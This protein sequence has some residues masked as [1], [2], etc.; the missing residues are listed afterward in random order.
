MQNLKLDPIAELLSAVSDFYE[1]TLTDAVI[2]IWER[3]LQ[4]YDFERVK[5]AFD[6]HMRDPDGGRFMPKLAHIMKHLEGIPTDNAAMAWSKALE[7]AQTHGAYRD[8]VFD[9][10]AIHAAIADMG[11]WPK[12]CRCENDQLSYQQHRFQQSYGAYKA[13]DGFTYPPKLLG[14]R[15][16]DDLYAKRGLPMPVPSFIG[17]KDEAKK[18]LRLGGDA[19]KT[20]EQDA[21]AASV[22]LFYKKETGEK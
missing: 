11:G 20:Q 8:V 18:V 10:A 21:I 12:F 16:A 15:M 9:D 22:A 13:Q 14:D 3:S 2:E 7:A 6:A 19:P 17:N 1:K 5:K 4:G